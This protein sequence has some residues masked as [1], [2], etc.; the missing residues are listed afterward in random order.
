MS[1]R[2][3]RSWHSSG[4]RQ[5]ILRALIRRDGNKCYF[6]KREIDLSLTNH[7]QEV[8]IEHIIPLAENGSNTLSNL[9]LAHSV[10]NEWAGRI[11]EEAKRMR[12]HDQDAKKYR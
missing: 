8:T 2:K 1:K 12:K 9:A 6:C 4:Q 3:R 5:R 11:Y 10:C 7:S